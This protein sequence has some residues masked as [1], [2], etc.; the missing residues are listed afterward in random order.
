MIRKRPQEGEAMRDLSV[1]DE[2][3]RDS[4]AKKRM[5]SKTNKR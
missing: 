3:R 5:P 1:G 4:L 2:A